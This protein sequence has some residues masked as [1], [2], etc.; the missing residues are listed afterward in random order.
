MM[1]NGHTILRGIQTPADILALRRPDN[2]TIDNPA[3]D[4]RA[5]RRPISFTGD[6]GHDAFAVS[7][8]WGMDE[9]QRQ[10]WVMLVDQMIRGM[11]KLLGEECASMAHVL[12]GEA[13][14]VAAGLAMLHLGAVNTQKQ[15]PLGARLLLDEQ[16]RLTDETVR[17]FVKRGL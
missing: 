1:N 10:L 7:Q 17:A 3:N 11:G 5:G 13:L 8:A 6:F 15:S 4:N 12:P 16:A 14:G 2:V 9:R